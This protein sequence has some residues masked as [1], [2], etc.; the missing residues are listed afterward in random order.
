MR[1]K[2][3]F[4]N[5]PDNLPDQLK[6]L[7][8]SS[9]IDYAKALQYVKEKDFAGARELKG[10]R[11]NKQLHEELIFEIRENLWGRK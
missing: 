7:V 8:S 3:V 6:M 1:V 4:Q 2:S 9:A 11:T 5:I 10:P